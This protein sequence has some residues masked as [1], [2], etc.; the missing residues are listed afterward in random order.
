MRTLPDTAER[1][2]DERGAA[3]RPSKTRLKQAMHELQALGE[4]L[5]DLPQDRFQA[6]PLPE[7][8][9]DA[10]LAFQGMRAR[11]AR[12]RQLQYIGKLMRS[13][14]VEPIREAVE[15]ARLGTAQDALALHEAERWRAEL[16]AGDEALTAWMTRHPGSDVQR[17]R[18][19]I[20]AARQEAAAA[21]PGE[22]PR[23]GR[24]YRE[25]FQFIKQESTDE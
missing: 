12:R 10:V 21:A 13:A 18:S 25:L 17:L 2:D 3:S 24:S 23:K 19:L 1:A 6:L 22:E 9:R 5:A 11:E 15:A 14:D 8:L 16:L 4:A 20:R 7:A